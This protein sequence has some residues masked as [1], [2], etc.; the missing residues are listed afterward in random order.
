MVWRRFGAVSRAFRPVRGASGGL[1]GACGEGIL[2]N[3]RNA[4][5]VE[6]RAVTSAFAPLACFAVTGGP[7]PR[8][9]VQ[10]AFCF[11]A[12][13]LIPARAPWRRPAVLPFPSGRDDQHAMPP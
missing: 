5:E 13:S 3:A 11:P 6:F 1:R 8:A 4:Q 2:R 7:P 10:R 12:W 9:R